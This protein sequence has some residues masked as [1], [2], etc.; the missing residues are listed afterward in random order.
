[1][2][3]ELCY[4]EWKEKALIFSYDDGTIYDRRLVDIFNKYGLKATFHLNS[5]KLGMELVVTPEE[6]SSLYK[7][8]EVA[9]H[10]VYHEYPTHLSKE[11]IV[12]EFYQDRVNL[13][14]LTDQMVR[15]CSYAYGE[16]NEEVSETLKRIG[17]VYSRT[18]EA[19]GNMR[20][21]NDFIHWNPSC[22]HNDVP[23]NLIYVNGRV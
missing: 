7:G 11:C 18:T 9:C 19:T 21:P 4:P 2:R 20:V 6:V 10:G 17:I 12:Q 23:E 16:Y 22:H 5:G 15:G 13:E 8:H 3:F 1:M 14:K